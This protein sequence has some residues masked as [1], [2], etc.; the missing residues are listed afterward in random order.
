PNPN[1]KKQLEDMANNL[2]ELLKDV[3]K[4]MSNNGSNMVSGVS[5][6]DLR[7]IQMMLSSSKN[8]GEGFSLFQIIL[9]MMKQ[10]LS[11][12]IFSGLKYFKKK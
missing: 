12:K 2:Q 7:D 4:T 1:Q 10:L 5:S 6:N 3:G 9:Q 11:K 8:G